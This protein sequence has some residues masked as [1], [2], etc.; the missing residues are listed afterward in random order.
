MDMEVNNTSLK[1]CRYS[2]DEQ[3]QAM[4]SE[5]DQPVCQA[6]LAD[7]NIDLG[8]KIIRKKLKLDFSKAFRKNI[9]EYFS[10]VGNLQQPSSP[11]AWPHQ[12]WPK[13]KAIQDTVQIP[14]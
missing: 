10:W 9:T 5:P 6:Q 4:G 14:L 8:S 7:T 13:V 3:N 1:V 12:D 2:T 11:P